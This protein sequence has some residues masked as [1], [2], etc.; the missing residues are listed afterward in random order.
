MITKPQIEHSELNSLRTL[1]HLSG[2]AQT[3]PPRYRNVYEM[4]HRLRGSK[5]QKE[6]LEKQNMLEYTTCEC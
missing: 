1:N 2:H 3:F 4:S 5:A 6:Q